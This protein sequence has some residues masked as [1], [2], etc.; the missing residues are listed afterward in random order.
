MVP[1]P[2]VDR[3][4]TDFRNVA[5]VVKE[6]NAQRGIYTIGT[7]HGVL[8]QCYTRN[9]I[10]PGKTS[11]LTTVQVPENISLR[12][13]ANFE[14]L[15]SGQGYDRCNCKTGCE[16]I[17]RCKCKKTGKLCNSKCHRRLSCQNK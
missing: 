10:I 8:E 9:Q 7:K 5:A 3:G 12:E 2:D 1:V 11:F 15:G 16:N 6:V 4:R 13:V 17:N 14:S